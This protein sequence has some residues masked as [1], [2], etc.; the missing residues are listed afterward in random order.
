MTTRRPKHKFIFI[1]PG[2]ETQ[3]GI[4]AVVQ[5]YK[6]TAFWRVNNCL[7]F[8]ST[9]DETGF[10]YKLIYLLGRY[11]LFFITLII[12]RPAAIS[13]HTSYGN[14][15]FRKTL[16]LLISRSLGVRAILHIHPASFY[17]F[18]AE[19][20]SIRKR[21]ITMSLTLSD[22]VIFLSDEQRQQFSNI[23]PKGKSFVMSNPV[24][25][26]KYDIWKNEW[27]KNKKQILY[28]GWIIPGKG[29][30]DIVDAIPRILESCSDAIFLFVGNKDID[31]LRSYI[32]SRGLEN[33]AI[34]P[35]WVE[36][37]EKINLLRTSRILILPSYTEGVP[38]VILEAMASH[39]PIITTPVGG[40]P[41]VI[42][43]G[44]TGL[45]IEPGNPD[46]IAKAINTLLDD[47]NQCSELADRAFDEVNKKYS[48]NVISQKLTAIYEIYGTIPENEQPIQP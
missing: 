32:A 3:G 40:I 31:N 8:S 11:P 16:Y 36:G 10:L 47:D 37:I 15:F 34:V 39:L 25:I 20:G 13:I 42:Q 41:S 4:T 26:E 19:G 6:K 7:E 9:I 45:F 46:D 22:R 44:H 17:D 2:S 28:L 23:I 30:Y 18:Y 35:G 21:L 12:H 14:S 27:K 5:N 1:A 24:D 33:S 38:N 43:D 29:V 48:L